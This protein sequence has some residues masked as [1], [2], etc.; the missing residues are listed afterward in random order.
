M[1]YIFFFFFFFFAEISNAPSG[2]SVEKEISIICKGERGSVLWNEGGIQMRF[3]ES[4]DVS[5]YEATKCTV[6]VS[7]TE[8]AYSRL[9]NNTKALSRFYHIS[10]SKNLNTA[11]TLKIFHRAAED[12]VHKLRFLASTD[13]SPPYNYRILDGGQFTSSYGEITV[14]RFSLYAICSYVYHYVKGILSYME[15]R[16]EAS[17]Y[18]SIRPTLR[19]SRHIWNLYLFIVK[20]CNIFRQCVKNHIQ[21]EFQD[22]VRKVSGHVVLFDDKCDCIT[23]CPNLKTESPQK[24]NVILKHVDHDN[25]L[26]HEHINNYVD[27]CPP[28]LVYSI[29]GDLNCL[30]ELKFTLGG[31]QKA[32]Q[33]SIDQFQL[34]GKH[35][36][37]PF[38]HCSYHSYMNC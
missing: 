23:V 7:N 6:Q 31:L 14:E 19:N 5:S 17:L 13:K 24:K 8:G 18:C 32:K 26:C 28:L 25:T 33:L 37:T 34:P 2:L 29:H 38:L 20:D 15:T 21:E 16:Y 1:L 3:E 35:C 22:N 36:N 4:K 30:L 12:D 27:G 10:S 11:V 9:P